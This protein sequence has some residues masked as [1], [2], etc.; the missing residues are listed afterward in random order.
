MKKIH[1]CLL[2]AAA[3][4]LIAPAVSAQDAAQKARLA[5]IRE[6]YSAAMKLAAKNQSA[7]SKNTQVFQSVQS[8]PNG[9][10]KRKVEFVYDLDYLE[11]MDLYTPDPVFIRQDNGGYLQEFLYDKEGKLMFVFERSD[12]GEDDETVEYRYYYDEEGIPFWKIEKQINVKTKKTLSTKQ[13]AAD[14]IEDASAWF[15]TR[16]ANDLM[17][18]FYALNV[19]YD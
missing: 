5:T 7:E 11:E 17:T 2:L 16:V 3:L 14:E 8:D 15:L 1:F 4:L 19:M 18:A 10:W 12:P 13:G 9:V 6:A